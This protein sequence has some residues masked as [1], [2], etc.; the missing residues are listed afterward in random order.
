MPGSSGRTECVPKDLCRFSLQPWHNWELQ[1]KQSHAAAASSHSAHM[2]SGPE[3][4]TKGRSASSRSERCAV[5]IARSAA[6]KTASEVRCWA[7]E[8]ERLRW[9]WRW[10]WSVA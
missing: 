7:T 9:C 4:N 8:T 5:A 2:H 1:S 10:C 6:E 3:G